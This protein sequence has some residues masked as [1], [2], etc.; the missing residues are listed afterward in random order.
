MLVKTGPGIKVYN[1]QRKGTERECFFM[2][3]SGRIK[4]ILV[5]ISHTVDIHDLEPSRR[6][7]PANSGKY[8][9]FI[10]RCIIFQRS[11]A[12]ESFGCAVQCVVWKWIHC[13]NGAQVDYH[14]FPSGLHSG[15]NEMDKLLN[16]ESADKENMRLSSKFKT[17]NTYE[18]HSCEINV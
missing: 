5:Q 17:L 16:Q 2:T 10:S 7:Q 1:K 13:G 11:T 18:K 9:S 14:T 6:K 12:Y 4:F 3:I 8:C 15:K